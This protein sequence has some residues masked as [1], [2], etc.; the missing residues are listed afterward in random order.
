[1]PGLGPPIRQFHHLSSAAMVKSRRPPH[2]MA[3]TARSSPSFPTISW[4]QPRAKGYKTQEN[5]IQEEK[6]AAMLHTFLQYSF[7]MWLASSPQIRR[8]VSEPIGLCYASRGQAAGG[9]GVLPPCS[10]NFKIPSDHDSLRLIQISL[11]MWLHTSCSNGRN[12]PE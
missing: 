4:S 8:R 1:M 11:K 7:Y 9:G 12:M 3:A 10:F 6:T 5:R 2:P